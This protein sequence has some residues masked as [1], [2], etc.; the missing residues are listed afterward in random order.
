[1]KVSIALLSFL[2]NNHHY[3]IIH[4][5]VFLRIVL[6]SFISVSPSNIN[7]LI[8]FGEKSAFFEMLGDP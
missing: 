1:M 7:F 3:T 8:A 2:F 4:F 5:C 6:D